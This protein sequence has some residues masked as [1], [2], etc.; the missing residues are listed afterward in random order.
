MRVLTL[1]GTHSRG[2]RESGARNFRVVNLWVFEVT[3]CLGPVGLASVLHERAAATSTRGVDPMF[4]D[5]A[6]RIASNFNGD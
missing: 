3:T 1:Q 4:K 2:A 6:G 5:L